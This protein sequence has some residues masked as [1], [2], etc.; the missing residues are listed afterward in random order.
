[1]LIFVLWLMSLRHTRGFQLPVATVRGRAL[2]STELDG[3]FAVAKPTAWTSTDVV[4]KVRSTLEKARR[5]AGKKKKFKVGHGGT[6]DPLATGVLV[7]GVGRGCRSLESYL[8]GEK[9]YRATGLLG[10]E[11]DTF[12]SDGQIVAEKPFEHITPE[13]FADCLDDFRGDIFQVPPMYSALRVDGRRLY[14][15]AREGITV[16]REPRPVH[17]SKLDLVDLSLPEFS[18]DVTC[19]GGTYI[20]SL[21]SDIGKSLDSLAHMT[22]LERTVQGPFHL[23]DCLSEEFF[24]D[25]DAI[26]EHLH[27]FGIVVE[28]QPVT[29]P[30]PPNN[31]EQEQKR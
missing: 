31:K 22:S 20:R 17:I 5:R 14:D 16:D 18:L 2:S 28:Q 6:L 10:S 9:T 26:A 21:I 25:S 19:S 27:N 11:T 29:P 24:G 12:D 13:A 3:I 8:K 30:P 7:L 15:L 1:M 23:G 4:Q